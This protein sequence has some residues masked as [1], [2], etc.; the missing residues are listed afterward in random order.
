MFLL[1]FLQDILVPNAISWLL[2]WLS[3]CVLAAGLRQKERLRE[4][5]LAIGAVWTLHESVAR[6]M[7]REREAAQDRVDNMSGK[8]W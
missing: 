7:T 8:V 5:L 3:S 1:T 6:R 2:M 4:A